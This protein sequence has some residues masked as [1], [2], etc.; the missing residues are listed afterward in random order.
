MRE[1]SIQLWLKWDV[2]RGYKILVFLIIAVEIAA[3]A[4]RRRALRSCPREK[5]KFSA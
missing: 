1:N 4:Q 3:A 2:A 5:F